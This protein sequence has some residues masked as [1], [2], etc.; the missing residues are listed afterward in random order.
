MKSGTSASDFNFGFK[1]SLK[2]RSDAASNF[3]FGMK[4]T[5]AR[6]TSAGKSNS[7]ENSPDRSA[8]N[9]R[10][11]DAI[12]GKTSIFE[13]IIASTKTNPFDAKSEIDDNDSE[14][15]E[16]DDGEI[17]LNSHRPIND[18]RRNRDIL[19]TSSSSLPKYKYRDRGRDRDAPW[20][21]QLE[22]F[23]QNGFDMGP[24]LQEQLL[25]ELGKTRSAS[26]KLPLYADFE[27][28]AENSSQVS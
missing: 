20:N 18:L 27:K 4:D 9:S 25:L 2:G 8:V 26:W 24:V 7:S 13:D 3:N 14:V 22:N 10:K 23:V 15:E 21:E 6:F 12:K 11:K 16:E 17:V 28:L 19:A 1:D 5:L